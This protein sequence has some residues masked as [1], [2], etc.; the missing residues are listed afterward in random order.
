MRNKDQ[1]KDPLSL[2]KGRLEAYKKRWGSLKK[3][4]IFRNPPK[5][6]VTQSYP[7]SRIWN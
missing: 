1:K 4:K 5:L 6:K 7:T 3:M 2:P